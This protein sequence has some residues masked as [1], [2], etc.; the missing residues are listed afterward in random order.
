MRPFAPLM[1]A[2]ALLV[3]SAVLLIA[4]PP[5]PAQSG[6]EEFI[7]GLIPEENLFRLVKR[8]RPLAEY[9][10]NKLGHKVKFTILSKYGDIIDRFVTREMDGAFWGAFSALLAFE[11]LDVEPVARPVSLDG[12]T[13]V[14]SYIIVRKDSGIE[15]VADLKDKTAAFVDRATATGFIFMLAYLRE[16]GIN[17]ID[18]F[19]GKYFFTGSHDSAVNAVLDG[20][21]DVGAVKSR[22]FNKMLKADPLIKDELVILARSPELPDTTL[23]LTSD[24]GPE[25][26][27]RFRKILTEMHNDPRG[28]EVLKA[29]GARSFVPAERG[30]FDPVIELAVKAGIDIRTYKYK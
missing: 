11:K 9:L 10:S 8:H 21:A 15:R 23:C 13:T 26:I 20:R 1:R 6:H 24:L 25:D 30:D 18:G 19:F 4:P 29:L 14:Q 7:I 3:L 17:D 5:L 12:S 2:I 28:K 27:G 22:I 16:N